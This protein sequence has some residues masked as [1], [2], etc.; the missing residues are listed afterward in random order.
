MIRYLENYSDDVVSDVSFSW[1][2]LSIVW[3][4][5]KK[6]R[7]VEH[8]LVALVLRVHR[9]QPSGVVCKQK[10]FINIGPNRKSFFLLI[11]H[12]YIADA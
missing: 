9:V 4:E 3:S 10:F 11:E 8:H 12:F 2:L 1:Q 7:H 6:R 5:W